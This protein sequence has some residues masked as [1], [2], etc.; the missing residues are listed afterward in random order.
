MMPAARPG[1]AFLCLLGALSGPVRAA[2]IPDPFAAV[3]AREEKGEFA[4]SLAQLRASQELLKAHR[5]HE[6]ALVAFLRTRDSVQASLDKGQQD[7]ARSALETLLPRLDPVRD[8]YL[9]HAAH[10]RLVELRDLGRRMAEEDV[11]K[12]DQLARDDKF[13]E[14][15]AIYSDIAQS[16]APEIPAALKRRARQAKAR[17]EAGKAEAEAV[18]FWGRTWKS[19]SEGVFTLAGW[20]VFLLAGGLLVWAAQA[21]RRKRK[22]REETLIALEDLTAE[23]AEREILSQGLMRELLLRLGSMRESEDLAADIDTLADIDGSAQA[24]LRMETEPV[25]DIPSVIQDGTAV[26]I[27]PFSLTPRQLVELVRAYFRQPWKSRLAGSLVRRGEQT[28]LLIERSTVDGGSTLID[29]WEALADGDDARSVVVRRMATRLAFETAQTRLTEDWRS[30]EAYREA[31]VCLARAE[32]EEPR[33]PLLEEACRDLQR[34]L[35]HDPANW[36]ARFHL[37]ATQ[38]KL[39]QNE[40]AAK[41][42]EFL[43]WMAADGAQ[44]A[45]PMADYLAKHPELLFTLRYNKAVSL[46]KVSNWKAHH[47]AVRL[48]DE[49]VDGATTPTPPTPP[50]T[51]SGIRLEMLAR[52]ARAAA[53]TFELES[54]PEGERS[55]KEQERTHRFQSQ[56]FERIDAERK[57]IKALPVATARLDWKAYSL[58][59]AVTHNAYGRACYLLGRKGGEDALREALTMSPDFAESYITLA[60]LSMRRR[61]PMDWSRQAEDLLKRALVI[62]PANQKAHYR[63]GELYA[64]PVFA[65]SLSAKE[66]L[67]KAELVPW[68]YAILARILAE[69]GDVEEAVRKMRRSIHLS[70]EPDHRFELFV[71]YALRVL[72][73]QKPPPDPG[74]LKEAKGVAS[75][76]TA[77]GK[78]IGERLLEEIRAFERK[79]RA[80]RTRPPGAPAS[81]GAAEDSTPPGP[82]P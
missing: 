44:G 52:S 33:E 50:G 36:I 79:V 39:G 46:S 45:G 49:L 76:L 75:K 51:A 64:D 54:S 72:A 42:F 69:E 23:A 57:W 38:R 53:L 40:S 20:S 30:F 3:L 8:A 1:I 24:N 71:R 81:G 28:L 6:A 19:A 47:E 80:E 66:H 9:L 17:A 10:A 59:F 58:S 65:D 48:L 4:A 2:E 26:Q 60:E 18:G 41:Q 67:A 37:G 34:S 7:Q 13:G 74:L 73:R 14:A 55:A 22:P 15:I 29:R 21:R 62:N 61:K 32:Q 43:E 27:G 78:E 56:V 35:R 68:S 5:E 11:A 16:K 82:Q 77:A 63:L 31:M 70:P 12:A 25:A